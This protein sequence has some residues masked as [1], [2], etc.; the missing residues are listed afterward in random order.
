MSFLSLP[1]T[2]RLLGPADYGRLALAGVFVGIGASLATLGSTFTINNRVDPRPDG[3]SGQIISALLLRAFFWTSAWAGLMVLLHATLGGELAVFASLTDTE[4][5]LAVGAMVMSPSWPI[6]SDL[7]TRR[8]QAVPFLVVAI[9]QAVCGAGSTLLSLFVFRLG[10]TSLFVGLLVSSII[11]FAAT[12]ILLR[13]ELCR[14]PKKALVEVSRA[15][16]R[17]FL[18]QGTMTMQILLERLLLSR[19]AGVHVLGLYTHSQRY[20]EVLFMATKSVTRGAMPVMLEEAQ[21]AQ[22]GFRSTATIFRVVHVAL[23]LIGILFVLFGDLLVSA[24]TNDRFTQ[25]HTLL[26]PWIIIILLQNASKP[27]IGTMFALGSAREVA[28]IDA[29]ANFCGIVILAVL[30]PFLGVW[31]ALVAAGVQTV[32]YRLLVNREAARYRK[33]AFHD[34]WVM[35]G[36]AAILAIVLVK[37]ALRPSLVASVLIWLG[38]S[39][40]I[41]AL[42]WQQVGLAAGSIRKTIRAIPLLGRPTEVEESL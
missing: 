35:W 31:G 7:L 9:A 34:A 33:I 36:S 15:G 13:E 40:F 10:S 22:S 6:I 32:S 21:D 17:F 37:T 39:S 29:R 8:G 18:A 11:P 24:L 20:K 1:L 27:Q 19:F 38:A 4:F 41:I 2:T 14:P 5:W 42:S 26:G 3:E 16:R 30:V 25:A 12:L 23:T 28:R